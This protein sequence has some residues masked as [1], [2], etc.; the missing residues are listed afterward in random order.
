M[1][2]CIWNTRTSSLGDSKWGI[3]TRPIWKISK[4][5]SKKFFEKSKLLN[6]FKLIYLFKPYVLHESP[7][8][9]NFSSRDPV[10]RCF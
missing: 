5:S 7:H 6:I 4:K 3:I 8:K 2:L 10:Y 1:P 9:L